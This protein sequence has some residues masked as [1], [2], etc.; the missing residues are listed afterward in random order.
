MPAERILVINGHPDPA[1]ERLCAGLC[2]AYAE[3]AF[4][5]GRT[6]RRIDIGKLSFPLVRSAADFEEGPAPPDIVAAQRDIAWADHLVIVHPL[7]LGGAP[8]LLKGFLE[9]AFRYGFALP[10]PGQDG[11]MAGLLGGRSGRL[12]VTMGMPAPVYRFWF[13]AFG[14]RAVQRSILGLAGIGPV[15]ASL[16]GSVGNGRRRRWTELAR[17]LGAKGR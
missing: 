16:I 3:A 13:G 2:A 12:I 14:V 4:R 1:P 7:W 11:P 17:R 9:Q 5:A 8:A 10:R 15:R 6:V